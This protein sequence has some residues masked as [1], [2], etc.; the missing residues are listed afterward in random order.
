MA[1]SDVSVTPHD[2]DPTEEGRLE[3]SLEMSCPDPWAYKSN[4][5]LTQHEAF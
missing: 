5:V 1:Q 2:C 3:D 4:P